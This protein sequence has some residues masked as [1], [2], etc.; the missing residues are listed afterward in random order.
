MLRLVVLDGIKQLLALVAVA[1]VLW[2]VASRDN[3]PLVILAAGALVTALV[4]FGPSN[5]R[6]DPRD[7]QDAAED[8]ARQR[9]RH[10]D[11]VF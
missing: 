9:R 1:L 5:S 3:L 8:I 11:G 2:A 10:S 4:R 7:A 6:P